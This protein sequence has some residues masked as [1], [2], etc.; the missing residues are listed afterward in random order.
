MLTDNDV[1]VRK[2]KPMRTLMCVQRRAEK[3]VSTEEDFIRSNIESFGNE[4]GETTNWIT[5]MYEVRAGFSE[6]SEEYRTL[7]YRIQ[8]GQQYQQNAIDKAKGI[9]CHPMPRYWHDRKYLGKIDDEAFREKNRAII[10]SRKPYFMIYIYPALKKQYNDYIRATNKNALREFQMTIDELKAIPAEALTPR[11]AEFLMF[12][13][14]RMPVGTNDCVM[15]VICKKI[16]SEF[17]AENIREIRGG[18]FNY[19]VLK[20]GAEY[21][22]RQAQEIGKIYDAY[23]ERLKSYTVTINSTKTDKDEAY[24]VISELNREF[25][26]ECISVCPDANVLC[27]ILLD[28]CYKRNSTKKFV[29]SISAHE[30]INNLLARNNGRISFPA[31][32][33]QETGDGTIDF[34]G[35]TFELKT[36]TITGEGDGQDSDRIE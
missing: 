29:W 28:L 17:D 15:N 30:I 11:Q 13:E 2:H 16:E 6:D 21:T 3:R 27:D 22:N 23:T 8:C 33:T 9:V 24:S 14:Y 19:F 12:Y 34:A 32:A 18:E 5:S 25:E 1:L 31:L 35:K 36:I 20:C 7:T 26:K 10:A 4:I